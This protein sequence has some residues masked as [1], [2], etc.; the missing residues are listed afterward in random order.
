MG[1]LESQLDAVADFRGLIMFSCESCGKALNGDDFFALGM[2]VPDPGESRDD[3]CEAELLDVVK[4]VDCMR[5]RQA[6]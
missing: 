1:A 5:A 4:H 2:R 6:G 3:Y